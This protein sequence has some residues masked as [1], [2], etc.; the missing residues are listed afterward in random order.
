MSSRVTFTPDLTPGD[1]DDLEFMEH[2]SR[3]YS[4]IEDAR[5]RVAQTRD[6]AIAAGCEFTEVFRNLRLSI[7]VQMSDKVEYFVKLIEDLISCCVRLRT[8]ASPIEVVHIM[9]DFVRLRTG[10]SLLN[11]LMKFGLVD[12]INGLFSGLQVQ[13]GI[14]DALKSVRGVL[15]TIE[16]VEGSAVIK[17]LQEV[18]CYV[19]AF[20]ISGTLKF[21]IDI[22]GF[23]YLF[24]E[25]TKKRYKSKLG[26]VRNL[27][28]FITYAIERIRA[29]VLTGDL[30]AVLMSSDATVDFFSK[31]QDLLRISVNLTNLSALGIEEHT[32]FSDLD[33][34]IEKGESLEKF[35]SR[36][37]SA[38]RRYVSKLVNQLKLVRDEN[39]TMDNASQFRRAPFSVL[40]FGHSGLGKTQIMDV[41]I[42]MFCKVH[43]LE[44][45]PRG[46]YAFVDGMKHHDGFREGKHT[47]IFD[48][49][50]ARIPDPGAVDTMVGNIILANNT[51]PWLL[52]MAALEKK[53]KTRFNPRFLIGTTNVID[54]GAR[55]LFLSELALR[56]RFPLIVEVRCKPEYM[57]NGMLD[58]TKLPPES[59]FMEPE[60]QDCWIFTILKVRPVPGTQRHGV[61]QAQLE[62]ICDF[63]HTAD[64]MAY[65][66]KESIRHWEQ[67]IQAEEKRASMRSIQICTKLENGVY[68]GCLMPLGQ[69]RCNL[70]AQMERVDYE[71]GFE[72]NVPQINIPEAGI[73]HNREGGVRSP[74]MRA[75]ELLGLGY[76]PDRVRDALR[77][78]REDLGGTLPGLTAEL[79]S[80]LP[81]ALIDNIA[82]I[83]GPFRSRLRQWWRPQQWVLWPSE[84][85]PWVQSGT[86]LCFTGTFAFVFFGYTFFLVYT[87]FLLMTE[88]FI[89]GRS[90]S[91]QGQPLATGMAGFPLVLAFFMFA[92]WIAIILALIGFGYWYYTDPI[93]RMAIKNLWFF[94]KVAYK[95]GWNAAMAEI[96]RMCAVDISRRIEERL[97]AILPN[98]VIVMLGLISGAI[99]VATVISKATT[100]AINVLADKPLPK[101]PAPEKEDPEVDESMK[102]ALD[103]ESDRRKR[104]SEASLVETKPIEVQ[105]DRVEVE[106]IKQV[107]EEDSNP[108]YKDEFFLT[109][110]HVSKKSISWKAMEREELHTRLSR[111]LYDIHV[112]KADHWSRGTMFGISECYFVVCKHFFSTFP[113]AMRVTQSPPDSGVT[114]SREFLID[115]SQ[116]CHISGEC[117][118]IWLPDLPMVKDCVDLLPNEPFRGSHKGDL[119]TF[120]NGLF[121]PLKAEY[122]TF[123]K[124][125]LKLEELGDEVHE[126]AR[127]E[128]PNASVN[129]DC[130][131]P[132]LL[133]TFYGPVLYGFHVAG[134]ASKFGYAGYAQ[135][136]DKH[137]ITAAMSI[138]YGP[139]RLQDSVLHLSAPSAERELI[140]LHYKSPVRFIEQGS[141]SVFGSVTGHRGKPK[142]R[143]TDT[144][145]KPSLLKRGYK[146]EYGPPVLAGWE[147]KHRVLKNSV[148]KVK[149]NWLQSHLDIVGEV[150]R[151]HVKKN[152]P[153][154]VFLDA[155]PLTLSE[156]I[157]GIPGR[158]F[159]DAMPK[160]TSAG[161][162]W[163]R[164]KLEFLKIDDKGAYYL[165]PEAQGRVDEIEKNLKLGIV[166]NPVF[167]TSLKDELLKWAK[168]EQKATR[169]FYG[170]PFDWAI[171][172]RR[173]CLPLFRIIQMYPDVFCSYPGMNVNSKQW[174]K[175]ARRLLKFAKKPDGTPGFSNLEEFLSLVAT[176]NDG[177]YVL[178][179]TSLDVK[180]IG[181]ACDF[182][183][184]LGCQC[185]YNE[186]D[187]LELRGVLEIL[188][189]PLIYFFGDLM[190]LIGLNPSGHPGTVIINCIANVE[191]LM[192]AYLLMHPE[193][194]CD[195]FFD[196]VA[197]ATYGDDNIMGI[198]PDIP[199]FNHMTIAAKLKELGMTYTMANKGAEPKPYSSIGEVSFL[200][201]YFRYDPDVGAVLAPLELSS[202]RK[203]LMKCVKSKSVTL[204]EQNMDSIESAVAEFFHY[205]KQTFERER[206][207]LIEVAHES[208]LGM[209][210]RPS[211]FPTWEELRDRFL[212]ARA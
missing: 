55:F 156:A 54:L 193:G 37:R 206:A 178:Y 18:I 155:R 149:S 152:V 9:W 61:Q 48:D 11:N 32:F 77:I 51:A 150:F 121:R 29:A 173:L 112:R 21:G 19:L 106:E 190:Q 23:D 80:R 94:T 147:P 185:S 195:D 26:F 168:I 4:L 36:E 42:S 133:N 111:N 194:R 192:V 124:M 38:D 177:D 14:D 31:A 183:Y 137:A 109:P 141:A 181:S 83:A 203:S 125:S 176:L 144:L 43:N 25:H 102:A 191:A 24:E 47:C 46:I 200:K 78:E 131:S 89:M 211:S 20:D 151:E 135:M 34:T 58:P 166:W 161:F 123:V 128:G 201:R 158:K 66:G 49:P 65:L 130:G 202:I 103:D 153:D 146:D 164:C 122:V 93:F 64:L 126:Y 209:Y 70:E 98:D 132:L 116:V 96:I 1:G 210:I 100:V 45:S 27:I 101:P 87:T 184:W 170:A 162:P 204:E 86:R 167:T 105:A 84:D 180:Q 40:Y 90:W 8:V 30:K 5:A 189:H 28:D 110:L 39:C 95:K 179:D 160:S 113:T 107:E 33:S 115:E 140:P 7:P 92:P 50:G 53:G 68:S 138:R 59:D 118:L 119:L 73:N 35:L 91:E 154:E 79:Q 52:P 44:D 182:L 186:E 81:D 145:M 212:K 187:L 134:N 136:L 174:E 62:E 104:R 85:H 199:W 97:G 3:V 143:V 127:W 163:N 82:N 188:R 169:L 196:K 67:T 88:F 72:F 129:G 120:K 13:A 63:E 15:D 159:V 69:C 6:A 76:D 117:Y 22:A 205:G 165:N 142:S 74:Y 17:K 56:R 208:G 99:V 16:V 108:W 10:K 157:N 12:K 114:T 175:L 139:V 57:S 148:N 71:E 171:V 60:Y 207:D 41:T 197:L 172:A 198:S 75:D 2:R